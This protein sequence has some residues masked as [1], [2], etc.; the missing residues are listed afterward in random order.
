[1][2]KHRFLDFQRHRSRCII[3]EINHVAYNSEKRRDRQGRSGIIRSLS[4]CV[5]TLMCQGCC[6]LR[7]NCPCTA[8]STYREIHLTFRIAIEQGH[9]RYQAHERPV[10]R[11]IRLCGA[12]ESVSQFLIHR[13]C[14]LF[15]YSTIRRWKSIFLSNLGH[16]SLICTKGVPVVCCGQT[17]GRPRVLQLIRF[18]VS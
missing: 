10:S 11:R 7:A 15:D 6:R 13:G 9:R 18:G 5:S 17:A 2:R 12:T 16:F 8:D 1:M 3:I 14:S 4:L